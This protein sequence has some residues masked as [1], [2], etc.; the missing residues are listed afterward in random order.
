MASKSTRRRQHRRDRR[1]A[2]ASGWAR[3]PKISNRVGHGSTGFGHARSVGATATAPRTAPSDPCG[4]AC[5]VA[6]GR[7]FGCARPAGHP[8]WQVH[9]CA[10]CLADFGEA[11]D[12][13]MRPKTLTASL[14]DVA[15]TKGGGS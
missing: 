7:S 4:A 1:K 15:R 8:D 14:G 6:G 12:A 9:L 11:T 2:K 10:E 13:R 3:Q 5:I